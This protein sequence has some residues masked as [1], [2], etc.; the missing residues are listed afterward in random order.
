MLQQ[1]PGVYWVDS[2]IRF[3]TNKTDGVFKTVQE[4]GGIA[5]SVRAPHSNFAVMMNETAS[6]LITDI[7]QQK[8]T[9]QSGATIMLLYRTSEVYENILKWGV[10]CSLE[11]QCIAKGNRICSFGKPRDST[12]AKCSRY[13]QLIVNVLCTNLFGFNQD[14]Y[15]TKYNIFDVKRYS[16]GH[17]TPKSC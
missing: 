3:K 16:S 10:L 5:L 6:Y 8:T 4:T 11:E 15:T 7:E 1:Y 13:D 9:R 2:S 14:K 17:L 12:W